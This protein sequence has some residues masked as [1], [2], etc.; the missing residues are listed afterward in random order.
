MRNMRIDL[1]Y[2]IRALR[3]PFIQVSVLPFVFA[4]LLYKTRFNFIAFLLGLGAVVLTHIGANLINDYADSKT[5]VDLLDKTFYGF[6]GGSKL[7]QEGIFTPGFYFKTAVACFIMAAFCV[8]FLGV[9]LYRP[10][11]IF[12]YALI[13]LLAWFYSVKPLAFS[14]HRAGE[15]II[16]TL[17]GPVLVMGGYF[18]QTGIFPALESFMLSLPF[19]FMTTAILF[20]NEVPG[21]EEEK[22][23]GKINWVSFTGA[24]NAYLT[25][26]ILTFLVSAAVALNIIMGNLSSLS[27][28]SLIFL[29][30]AV[31]AA[32]IL[33]KDFNRKTEL[34]QAS[35]LTIGMQLFISLV[36]ITDA[37]L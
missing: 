6:F 19:G 37:L 35:K 18:I 16:F 10:E 9:V 14:Y 15:I 5:G 23:K 26:L 8:I 25:Y 33:K 17:F 7:I 34:I 11:V 13:L 12:F 28:L 1:K 20:V 22:E 21:F 29:S 36:L 4:S 30:M 32:V 24:D 27:W 2:F 31:K 3:L